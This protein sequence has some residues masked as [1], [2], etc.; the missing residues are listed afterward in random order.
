[1]V[2]IASPAVLLLL[3]YGADWTGLANEGLVAA[4]VVVLVS[5]KYVAMHRRYVIKNMLFAAREF[6]ILLPLDLRDGEQLLEVMP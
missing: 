4:I 3:L 6:S 1:M 5:D 2:C